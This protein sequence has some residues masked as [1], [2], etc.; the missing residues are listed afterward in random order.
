MIY[1]QAAA[2]PIF[3]V[4][5]VLG[6]LGGAGV[7]G[8]DTRL[9]QDSSPR[10][11]QPAHPARTRTPGHPLS[12]GQLRIPAHPPTHPALNPPSTKMKYTTLLSIASITTLVSANYEYSRSS[13]NVPGIQHVLDTWSKNPMSSYPTDF[14][15]GIFPKPLHSHNDYW[16][17]VPVY[18]AL[19]HG[20]ISIEAD[21][22]HL[23]NTLFIGHDLSSLTP[24][25]TLSSLYIQ[26]LLS[27]LTTKSNPHGSKDKNG[28]FDT[29]PSQTLY[30][31][32]D[33]KTPGP[34]TLPVV[35]R[36]LAPLRS[37]GLLTTLQNGS[38]HPGAVTPVFTG[39]TRMDD[40]LR[41][42]D[43]DYFFDA[44]VRDIG[45]GNITREL[46]PVVSGQ[47]SAVVG[48]VGMEGLSEEQVGTVKGLTEMAA[49]KGILV[50][51]WDTPDWP[52][53]RRDAVWGQ[54]VK[55]GIGLLNVDD[56]EAAAEGR[57]GGASSYKDEDE[58]EDEEDSKEF[59]T[60]L[61][62]RQ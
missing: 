36:A 26:P 40:I 29:T 27:I 59:L 28:I 45:W 57:W 37:A 51:F 7:A 58:D 12:S 13:R 41:E 61:I 60:V 52:R 20:A 10:T 35:I 30:L 11:T 54:L 48:E 23:N 9:A 4:I 3:G 46:S 55:A 62:V 1:L 31:F 17:D 5:R 18:T 22:W 16:R 43:R 24:L 2:P 19:S 53:S 34:T 56:L 47:L 38:L 8:L 50:R 44:S 21:I 39:S 49:G 15:R 42:T 14:T 32:L 25:R 33:L 6:V